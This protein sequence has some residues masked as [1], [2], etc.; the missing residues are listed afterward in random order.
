MPALPIAIAAASAEAPPLSPARQQLGF[1]ISAVRAAGRPLDALQARIGA[2]EQLVAD[3]ERSSGRLNELRA[4]DRRSL[5]NWLPDPVG[6]ARSEPLLEIADLAARIA[7]LATNA[8]AADAVLPDL[9]AEKQQAVAAVNRCAVE[10]DDALM[11]AC[12]EAAA[13]LLPALSEACFAVLR[14][15]ARLRGL[16]HELQARQDRGQS[17]L[18]AGVADKIN[19]AI[20]A[21]K[22][23]PEV[24]ADVEGARCFINELGADPTARLL[25]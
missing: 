16:T 18:A 24:R 17:R 1:A 14:I 5:G 20:T 11:L 19:Q 12:E 22:R 3:H 2:L 23:Q 6:A 10:L 13:E 8:A 15:E 21:T 25:T 7:D 9:R 4:L